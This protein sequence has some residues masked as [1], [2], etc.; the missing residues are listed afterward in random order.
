ML[1]RLRL[2]SSHLYKMIWNYVTIQLYSLNVLV[3]VTK[4]RKKIG[5]FMNTMNGLKKKKKKKKKKSRF[6][7]IGMDLI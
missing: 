5:K 3:C 4:M 1:G 7:G 2:P 6:L